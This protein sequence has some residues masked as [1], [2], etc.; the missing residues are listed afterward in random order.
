MRERQITNGS[1]IVT[2]NIIEKRGIAHRVIGESICVVRERK[3]ADC[4]VATAAVVMDERVCS[5]GSVVRI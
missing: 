4:V 1:V 5:N 3:G 2:V